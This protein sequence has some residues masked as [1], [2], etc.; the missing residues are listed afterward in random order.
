MKWLHSLQIA[1]VLLSS[2]KAQSGTED[3]DSGERCRLYGYIAQAPRAPFSDGVFNL[4]SMRPPKHCRSFRSEGVDKAIES[5]V[6]QIT[7]PDLKRLFS[8]AF[9]NTLDTTIAWR[10]VSAQNSEEELA[11]IITGDIPAMWLR[12]S[13]QQLQSYAPLLQQSS[14]TE[15]LASLFRG[16]INL[17]ARYLLINPYCQAF[18]PPAESRRP[19][20]RNWAYSGQYNVT[21]PYDSKIVFECKW[22]LDSHA[23]FLQLSHTYYQQTKDLDF[24]GKFSW[25]STIE[26]ILEVADNMTEQTTYE[27]DGTTKNSSYVFTSFMNGG[28]G[29][30]LAEGTGLI[31]VFF[32]PSDD[33]TLYQFF[34]P[35]NMQFSHYLN[36]SAEIME[37]L[38]GDDKKA[39]ARRMKDKAAS[40]RKAIDE[41]GVVSTKQH[42]NVYAYE[43]DGYGGVNLMDD[44]KQ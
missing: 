3:D 26:T 39:L 31:N 22:E 14:S 33:D 21:P 30:P 29:S 27:A 11:F 42:G 20:E 44:G 2:V 10:G 17:Q 13:A 19:P 5:T 12:D 24:F 37:K 36:A 35:G 16:A 32:R 40:V 8:N 15:S 43:V 41:H 28:L 9:P 4:S 25:V 18:Q 34:I 6:S 7:D 23:S 1:V 38:P